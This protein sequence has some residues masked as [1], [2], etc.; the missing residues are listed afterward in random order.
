MGSLAAKATMRTL[1]LGGFERRVRVD[2]ERSGATKALSFPRMRESILSCARQDKIKLD[3]QLRGNDGHDEPDANLSA[4]NPRILKFTSPRRRPGPNCEQA[5]KNFEN[6]I[7]AFAGT[8]GVG[9]SAFVT[10]TSTGAVF[11]DISAETPRQCLGFTFSKPPPSRG[12]FSFA[13]QISTSGPSRYTGMAFGG[14]GACSANSPPY[15]PPSRGHFSFAPPNSTRWTPPSRGHFSF[16]PRKKNGF[17]LIE[18]LI[19]IVILGIATVLATANLFQT[20]EEAL[21]QEGEKWL[22]VLQTARDEAAFGGRVI[23]MKIAGDEMHFFERDFSDASRWNA[24]TNSA[25]AT[26]K[27]ADGIQAQLRIGASPSAAKE[28]HIAFFPA[29][30]AEP[31]D[32]VLRGPV[33]TRKIFGDAIGNLRLSK[34]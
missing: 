6:W 29:G 7:P 14:R 32:L 16:A 31:F 23:A 5:L 33:G 3:F 20:D 8:T 12:H 34:E 18:I 27:I 2:T 22:A 30:V 24:S 10:I 28:N 25:L 1:A 4:E 26:R 9:G 17:T 21:Q 19:V 11:H 13:P 15:P